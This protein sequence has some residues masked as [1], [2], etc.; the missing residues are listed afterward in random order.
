MTQARDPTT[1]VMLACIALAGLVLAAEVVADT[2]VAGR[3]GHRRPGCADRPAGHAHADGE[4][5]L[6]PPVRARAAELEQDKV[7]AITDWSFN[8]QKPFPCVCF[9][10]G[11]KWHYVWTRDLSYAADLA[12][13]RL[14]PERTKTSLRFKLSEMR[15][16]RQP[17]GLYVGAGHRFGRQLAISTDRVVWFLAA[18]HLLDDPAFAE[19]TWRA[20][21]DTLAQ[22]RA[23][24]F[25][26]DAG[27]YRG[28]TSF[29]DWREQNYPAWTAKD[30]TSIAQGF[31]LSTN[32]LHYEALRTG[33]ADGARTQGRPRRDLRGTGAGLAPGDRASLLA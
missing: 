3:P 17:Q 24:A 15:N 25:E 14:D 8:H 6:R 31:A 21:N 16:P 32:V 4:P 23:Y 9:E 10:T 19:E 2:V 12:L 5:D 29:L 13:A 27:L 30:T 26:P 22:D 18:R 7:D 28:E 20:L 11:E 33:R 1:G